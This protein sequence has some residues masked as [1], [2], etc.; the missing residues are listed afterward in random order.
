MPKTAPI[1]RGGGDHPQ[2]HNR[3]ATTRRTVTEQVD[4]W[5]LSGVEM[6]E[7]VSHAKLGLLGEEA[8]SIREMRPDILEIAQ[9]EEDKKDHRA[10]SHS[11]LL[12]Q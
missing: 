2:I 1:K 12:H 10:C 9:G 3:G 6:D 8:E 4:Q 5:L 11:L 7:D